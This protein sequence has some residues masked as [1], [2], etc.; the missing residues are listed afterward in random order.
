MQTVLISGAGVAGPALAYWLARAGFRPTVVERSGG[1][2]SSGNPVDVRGAALPVVEEMGIVETLRRAATRATAM[3]FIDGGGRPG[4]R[5][6]MSATRSSKGPA[7]IEIA[8]A[9][10]AR[11][12][13]EAARDDAEFVFDDTITEMSQDG[14]GVDVTFERGA[15]R[16]FDLVVGADGLHS[17]VRR[18]GFGA[19]ADFVRYLGIYVATT[20]LGEVPEYPHDVLLYN[21]PGRLVSVHPASGKALVAFIFRRTPVPGFDYRDREQH[22]GIL[23]QAYRDDNGWRVPELLERALNADD[24]YFDAVCKVVLPSWSNGRITLLGDSAA[25]VSLLGDGSSLAIAGAR[26]LARALAGRDYRAA[27]RQYEYE[28][29]RRTDP[30]RRG[31]GLAAAMLVPKSRAGIV[32]RNAAARLMPAGR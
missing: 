29:R 27:L 31:A 20:A 28:H 3:R 26:T 25:S 13:F 17:T 24:L 19:E 7:E 9:D 4:R 5:M 6:S 12:L 14:E 16:R 21:S 30:R 15:P 10:L 2:R 23:G 22:R 11:I 32:T 8:R 18:I 1:Q